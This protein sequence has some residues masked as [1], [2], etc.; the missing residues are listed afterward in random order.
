MHLTEINRCG[1]D[2][3]IRTIRNNKVGILLSALLI[4][5]LTGATDS[6][7][8]RSI[9]DHITRHVQISDALIGINHGNRRAGLINRGN[10]R[11][12]G[13]TILH[14]ELVELGIEV[15]DAIV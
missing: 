15:A 14:R 9:D 4:P 10:V 11:F 6:G 3:G 8:H 13:G 7:R 2:T 12:N 1:V 5:H